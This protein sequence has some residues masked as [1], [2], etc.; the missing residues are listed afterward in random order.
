MNIRGVF[1]TFPRITRADITPPWSVA[2][3]V[4][5]SRESP[6]DVGLWAGPVRWAAHVGMRQVIYMTSVNLTPSARIY[7]LA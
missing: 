3:G 1:L 5:L 4:G 6:D 2:R 7:I